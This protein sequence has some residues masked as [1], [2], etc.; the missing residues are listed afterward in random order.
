MLKGGT[1]LKAQALAE[2]LTE[3]AKII[4]L[5][6]G[7]TKNVWKIYGPILRHFKDFDMLTPCEQVL[8]VED[9]KQS[10]GHVMLMDGPNTKGLNFALKI[11]TLHITVAAIK[12]TDDKIA[13]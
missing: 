3:D 10:A 7:Q 6:E 5:T 8:N 13:L 9:A 2:S 11:A 1:I 4:L 12:D